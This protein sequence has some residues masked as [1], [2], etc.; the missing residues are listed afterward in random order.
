MEK[1]LDKAFCIICN[2][3]FDIS[4]GGR[5]Q[6]VKHAETLKH[7]SAIDAST[8]SA[9]IQQFFKN[10][11]RELGRTTQHVTSFPLNLMTAQDHVRWQVFTF[12]LQ[13][14]LTT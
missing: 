8:S 1:E 13:Q 14:L 5:S 9:K 7:K 3:K 12:K 4:N 11:K 10:T 6:I 2:S